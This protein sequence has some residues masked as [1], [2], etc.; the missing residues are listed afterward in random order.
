VTSRADVLGKAPYWLLEI[1]MEGR[2]F[3]FSTE[4]LEVTRA[5]GSTVAFRGGL[6]GLSVSRSAASVAV[7]VSG[8]DWAL[9]EAQGVDIAS[10]RATLWR[11]FDGQNLNDAELIRAG[12]LD[13]PEYGPIPEPLT[14]SIVDIDWTDQTVVPSG[15]M[16]IDDTTWPVTSPFE[17]QD[18][19]RGASYPLVIGLPGWCYLEPGSTAFAFAVGPAYLVEYNA[20]TAFWFNSKVVFAGHGLAAA[21]VRLHDL[22]DG[23]Y[24]QRTVKYTEDLRGRRVAYVDFLGPANVV[25]PIDGHAYAVSFLDLAGYGAGLEWKG[26]PI[27]GAG[28]LLCYLLTENLFSTDRTVKMRVD[29]GAQEAQRAYLDRWKIDCVIAEPADVLAWI[30]AH[31]V[32]ILPI[33]EVQGPGGIYFAV[34]RYDATAA[35]V[36]LTIDLDRGAHLDGRIRD[37]GKVYNEFVLDYRKDA[38]GEYLFR[39]TLTAEAEA[40]DATVRGSYL[41]RISQERE[42][43]RT[44]VSGVRLKRG[45]TDVVWDSGTADLILQSWALQHAIPPVAATIRG[46]QGLEILR[47]GDV[48]ALNSTTMYWTDRLAIVEDLTS[49]DSGVVVLDVSVLADPLRTRRQ[50]S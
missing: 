42:R 2:I 16:V 36:V 31:L 11:W 26:E 39:R 20:G 13:R 33:R 15:D 12:R 7:T 28:Q 9:L 35:D 5:N 3:R 17:L 10:S 44:G 29:I 43:A 19:A 40:A 32:P 14:F 50:T 23:V 45:T 48:I 30:R 25:R 47:R 46:G 41:C 34:W 21:S 49:D 4:P 37:A 24:E 18:G 27:R 6:S 8:E 22:S 1:D 38:T